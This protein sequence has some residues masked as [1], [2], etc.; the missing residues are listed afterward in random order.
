VMPPRCSAPFPRRSL[1]Y[2]RGVDVPPTGSQ[3]QP[4]STAGETPEKSGGF[5][6]RTAQLVPSRTRGR[7][8][9][10]LAADLEAPPAPTVTGGVVSSMAARRMV[11]APM[12]PPESCGASIAMR[13]QASP[14]FF[15]T[16]VL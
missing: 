4:P 3:Q 13:L 7:H 5:S 16:I 12:N 1:V 6:L 11:G 8:D 9:E 14:D 2:S 10:E 15:A